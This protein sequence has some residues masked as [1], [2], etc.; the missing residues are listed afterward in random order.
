MKRYNSLSSYKEYN[1]KDKSKEELNM[2]FS[3]H[4][5]ETNT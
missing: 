4:K 5:I 3:K 2:I 1:L